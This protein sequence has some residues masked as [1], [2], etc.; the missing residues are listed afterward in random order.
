MTFVP[1]S[2]AINHKT[3]RG[4]TRGIILSL[5]I[6]KVLTKVLAKLLP[7]P[8]ADKVRMRS[9][10]EGAL[11]LLT[12]SPATSQEVYLHSNEIMEELNRS[13]GGGV[14]KKLNFKT[15]VQQNETQNNSATLEAAPA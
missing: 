1:L 2:K 10:R 5:Q 14:I 11:S 12:P 9:Y 13:L 6:E 3:W 15:M 4:S 7:P 8:I